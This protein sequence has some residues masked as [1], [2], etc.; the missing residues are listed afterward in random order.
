[1]ISG[2][3][4]GTRRWHP[5]TPMKIGRRVPCLVVW[6]LVSQLKVVA[7][8]VI[9]VN[10]SYGPYLLRVFFDWRFS[11]EKWSLDTFAFPQIT[12]PQPGCTVVGL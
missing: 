12:T 9:S 8:C 5:C 2:T 7:A 10:G 3:D 1:M 11:L 6:G 4:I